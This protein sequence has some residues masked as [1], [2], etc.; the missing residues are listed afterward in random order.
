MA[1]RIGSDLARS[2][3][4][5][6]Q[7]VSQSGLQTLSRLNQSFSEKSSQIAQSQIAANRAIADSSA[8]IVE[9]GMR[10]SAQRSQETQQFLQTVGQIGATV[11]EQVNQRRMAE[12]KQMQ[13]QEFVQAFTELSQL[14]TNAD[15][16]VT[17]KGDAAFIQSAFDTLSKFPNIKHED[18]VKLIDQAY[19]AS[20]RVNQNLFTKTQKRT[21]E[22]NNTITATKKAELSV[23]LAGVTSRLSTGNF[24]D[25]DSVLK[26]ADDIVSNFISQPTLNDLQRMQIYADSLE[27]I[28]EN[29]ESGLAHKS[30]LQQKASSYS[31]LMQDERFTNA[32][33]RYRNGDMTA[34]EWEFTMMTLGDTYDIPLANVRT[35]GDPIGS[36]RE[37]LERRQVT[38]QL[39]ALHRQGI[40]NDVSREQFDNTSISY[41]AYAMVSDPQVFYQLESIYKDNPQFKT[42]VALRDTITEYQD[43][44]LEASKESLKID[45]AFAVWQQ[46]ATRTI[47]SVDQAKKQ[48]ADLMRVFRE[49]ANERLVQGMEGAMP[50]R[51]QYLT[52]QEFLEDM[53][54]WYQRGADIMQKEK[55]LLTE[56]LKPLARRLET[57]GLLEAVEQD[58]FQLVQDRYNQMKTSIQEQYNAAPK[59]AMP[60]GQNGNFN[61]GSIRTNF[62]F[63]TVTDPRDGNTMLV[64]FSA[65]VASQVRITSQRGERIHPISGKQSMHA[66][67]DIAAPLGTP[68]AFY[69][70]GTVDAIK[71]D[72]D[73]YGYYIDIKDRDGK[74]HRF[75]HLK[76]RSSLR[77]GQRVAPGSV[78]GKVGSTGGSTGAHLHWEIRSADRR[79]GYDGT[80]D[81]NALSKDYNSRVSQRKVRG[82]NTQ[83]YA[84]LPNPYT[85]DVTDSFINSTAPKN[86]LIMGA[87]A[88][89]SGNKL[90]F[91]GQGGRSIEASEVF[92][93]SRPYKNMNTR[94]D[95]ANFDVSQNK[96]N[97]NYGYSFLAK[98]ENYAK[99]I[100]EVAS[101]LGVPGYWLADVIGFESGFDTSINQSAGL[102]YTGLIQ[103]G[104]AA[105]ERMGTSR[106]ELRKM[107]FEQQMEY[108]Y[109]YFN[110]PEFRGRLNSVD[111]F[112]AAVWGGAGL[113]SKIE[114]DP[115]SALE[116]SDGFIN[117]RGYLGK[118]GRDVG[119]RYDIPY[120]NGRR[121]R[122]AAP[123]HTHYTNGC[124]IC[125]QMRQSNSFVVHEGTN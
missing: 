29:S 98:N 52:D 117:F 96:P 51:E 113:V 42:M 84:N 78:L 64:P 101:R 69:D 56:G 32:V 27:V 76:N 75:A 90:G 33:Q 62:N 9:S 106:D 100:N 6:A 102:P 7:Q 48:S 81:I 109:E 123:T 122:I 73:G 60:G 97:N 34:Q 46:G 88:F 43:A 13:Q 71:T 92:N 125:S 72:P 26:E 91:I 12:Q 114:N 53:R 18:K 65:D 111:K 58:N 93:V 95:K 116:V 80:Y 83:L 119:R 11:S 103:F 86:S 49:T 15:S 16:I 108:V 79:Y 39:E 1:R 20:G 10:A 124:P 23:R 8:R 61:Q 3:R 25:I 87:S 89:L 47:R 55:A 37:A 31:R 40:A 120:M 57:Y 107:N 44:R 118:L 82:D 2:I 99:K 4:Q 70:H 21:E 104:D 63:G 66:G 50:Q 94:Y 24:E 19:K 41:Y 30:K 45:K 22:I 5:E 38:T 74:I 17:E 36:E 115:K 85:H 54:N 59:N 14:T 110:F 77:V 68:I 121:D 35:L 67:V 28:A 112:L 105:A